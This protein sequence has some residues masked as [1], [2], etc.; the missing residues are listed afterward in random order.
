M[1]DENGKRTG[2]NYK[3]FNK[4]FGVKYYL[5]NSSDFGWDDNTGKMTAVEDK[6]VVIIID[7]DMILLRPLTTDF[8]DHTFWSPFH[9]PIERKKKVERGTP[10]G[11]TYG[12]SHN[13]MKFSYLAGPDSLAQKVDEK[14]ADLHYQ[15]GAP[16]IADA[17]D[18]QK[19]VWRWADLVPKVHKAKPQLMSEMYAYCLAAADTGLPHEVVNSMMISAVDAYGEGWELIDEL[20]NEEVCVS[21]ITPNQSRHPLPTLLHYCQNY[22][23]GDVLFTKYLIP[24]DIFTCQKPLLIEPSVDA[25]SPDKAYKLKLGGQKEML[26]PKLHKRH[27][28]ATCAMTSIVNEASLFFKLHHCSNTDA[29]RER[30]L[31][32]LA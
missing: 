3:Y 14:T 16:Y 19:I 26:N 23:A 6:A 20:N 27:V 2:N 17:R 12:L 4:P 1:K 22:G 32:L 25:M 21:G 5:E 31:D 11:Q 15:V 8:S 7:P 10:F 30:T 28:F 29:N 24:D 18:M 9:R 13:W